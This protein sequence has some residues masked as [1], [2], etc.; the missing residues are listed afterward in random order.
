MKNRFWNI[1]KTTFSRTESKVIDKKQ[2]IW[3][4]DKKKIAFSTTFLRITFAQKIN[5]SIDIY[6]NKKHLCTSKIINS[7]L[8]IW[9]IFQY[10]SLV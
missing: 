10:D 1:T 8:F 7:Q 2:K 9:G 5:K 4:L 6:L 3:D